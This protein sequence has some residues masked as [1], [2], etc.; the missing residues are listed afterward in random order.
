MRA[1]VA[2]VRAEGSAGS[3]PDP[4]EVIGRRIGAAL[5]DV[6]LMA[7]VFVVLGLVLGVGESSDGKASIRLEGTDALIYFAL[8]L[9]YYF[10]TEA[11]SAQTLGKRLLGLRVVGRDG[12]RAGAG[13]IAVRTVLRVV[14]ALPLLYL[15]GLIVM[16][17][18][19]AKQRIGDL[20]AG[21]LVTSTTGR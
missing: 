17:A 11:A 3:K 15:L 7:V 12:S 20:A 18:T 10:A 16:L 8:V 13:A 6:A 9:L 2:A 19:P 21:T 5:L 14:D 1:R 4:A